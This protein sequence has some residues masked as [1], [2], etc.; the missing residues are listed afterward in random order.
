MVKITY[1]PYQEIVVHEVQELS[2]P[3]FFEKVISQLQAQGQTG[4]IPSVLWVDGIA[5][6]IS[7]FMPSED[8]VRDQIN[9]KLHYASVTFT[10]TSFSPE[11]RPIVAG[12]EFVV[13]LMKAENNPNF[14]DLVKFLKDF[15]STI[16]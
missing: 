5:F 8:L 11:K 4:V 15:K 2:V 10:R 16:G 3:Q 7:N 14:L 1:F 13:R 6:S 9:G 12:K